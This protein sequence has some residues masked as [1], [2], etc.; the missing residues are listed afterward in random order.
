MEA[1][2]KTY[3]AILFDLDNTILDRTQ[4]FGN[5]TR[6]FLKTYFNHLD[7]TQSLHDRIIQLDQDGYKEKQ[8]LFSELLDELPWISKPAVQELLQF[9]GT[10]YVKNAMLMEHASEVIRH[11][12]QK[13]Y[14][15]GLITN[16]KTSIQYG[17]I[18][19]LGIRIEFDCIVVSEEAGVKKP[20]PRIFEI[21]LN[22]L[23]VMA[24][25]CLF[26]GDHPA[27]DIGG[28]STAGMHTVW[29]KVNQPWNDQV[30]ARPLH[31]IEKLNALID[32][33]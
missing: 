11:V 24:G 30:E 21:A 18:D 7:D 15:T 17:K 5:L 27:N 3:K 14:L 26:V 22:K 20:D 16:G 10:E 6:S 32:L 29:L 19:Q 2:M 12:K 23:G 8:T 4:T 1:N 13:G 28:A 33:I 25:E 31:T 9:Y